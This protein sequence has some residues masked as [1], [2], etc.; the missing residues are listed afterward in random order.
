MK[1]MFLS[2]LAFMA[3][4]FAY[5]QVPQFI[6]YQ[7]V[8]RNA[9]GN[10]L[11]NQTITVRLT[12]HANTPSGAIAYLET[13]TVTTNQFGLFTIAVGRATTIPGGF[14][15]ISWDSGPKYLKV[16]MDA[17]AGTNF[18]NMGTTQILSVPYAL[19]A[20]TSGSSL[21]GPTGATGNTGAV[22]SSG[23]TGATGATG[24]T[25]ATGS[26]GGATGATG[27]TGVTGAIGNT[28]VTGPT[29]ATGITGI[30]GTTGNTGA[31]GA[32]G[33]TGTG[34][35]GSTGATGTT[36]TNG[37][38]G[39]TILS[40]TTTPAAGLGVNGD[41]YLNTTTSMLYGPKTAGAWGAGVSLKGATGSTGGTGATGVTGAIGTTGATGTV[42]ITFTVTASNN[43]NY[44]I[45]SAA[46]YVSGVTTDPTLV[47]QRGFTYTFNCTGASGHPFRIST[48]NVVPGVSFNTGVT[49]QDTNGG[50][51]TFK[52]PMDAP[53]TLYYLC[54]LHSNMVGTLTIQ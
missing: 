16:E 26:G 18:T 21:P 37:T 44:N 52:V 32:T 31:T 1:K 12:I 39:N 20:E 3:S 54:T 46:D 33:T 2:L 34:I 42:G 50:T 35:T 10:A 6:N 30:T 27:A 43:N 53:N 11:V 8:A 38:D 7:A 5:T 23:S 49:N 41:F 36:G 29:G 4:Y 9:Q 28:G 48:S 13:D 19:Y 45:G 15:G 47:L 24:P 25:G 22:G 40:G 14:S 51:L 17:A